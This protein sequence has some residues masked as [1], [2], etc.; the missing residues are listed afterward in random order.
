MEQPRNPGLAKQSGPRVTRHVADHGI[1][2]V[3]WH[4][5]TPKSS[6]L[7]MFIAGFSEG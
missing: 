3:S 1:Y 6:S 4:G 7:E 5:G 2:E